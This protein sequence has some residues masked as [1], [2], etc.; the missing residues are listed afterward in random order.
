MYREDYRESEFAR[1]N[2]KIDAKNKGSNLSMTSREMQSYY[3]TLEKYPST[4]RTH[5]YH[6][7]YQCDL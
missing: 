4:N 6:K 5:F 3:A 1:D 2:R 7:A